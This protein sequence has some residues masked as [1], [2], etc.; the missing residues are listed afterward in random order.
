MRIVIDL[1][2]CQT[3]GSRTRG[4]GRYS[5]DLTMA[6]AAQAEDR[7][8]WLALNGTFVD[9][10]AQIKQKFS[11]YIP[12]ERM[13]IY[14]VPNAIG[15]LEAGNSWRRQAAERI[16]EFSIKNIDPDVVHI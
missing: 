7:D 8:I 5:T 14:E 12:P 15:M 10:I 11:P 9:S 6:I 2:S 1:Q 4:I 13:L 16:R 3:E